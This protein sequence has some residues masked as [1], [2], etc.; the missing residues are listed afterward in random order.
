MRAPGAFLIG[1]VVAVGPA[2][3]CAAAML[4][5]LRL[6]I[7]RLPLCFSLWKGDNIP[8]IKAE[9]FGRFDWLADHQ[10]KLPEPGSVD[11]GGSNRAIASIYCRLSLGD[12]AAR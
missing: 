5:L 12:C 6:H 11:E 8:G 3:R 9:P 4:M 1:L 10:P 7:C 2:S